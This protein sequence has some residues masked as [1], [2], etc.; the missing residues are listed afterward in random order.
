MVPTIIGISVLVIIIAASFYVG[1][2]YVASSKESNSHYSKKQ[3]HMIKHRVLYGVND[4]NAPCDRCIIDDITIL[5][6]KD[7]GLTE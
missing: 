7:I 5:S 6:C 4:G 2:K 3:K 1:I